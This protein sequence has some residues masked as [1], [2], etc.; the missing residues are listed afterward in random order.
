V[1]ARQL[2]VNGLV[3]RLATADLLA[4]DANRLL[5]IHLVCT[6]LLARVGSGP[7][8]RK[9]LQLGRVQSAPLYSQMDITHVGSIAHVLVVD[10]VVSHLRAADGLELLLEAL[11]GRVVLDFVRADDKRVGFGRF[12]GHREG[13]KRVR[14]G[15]SVW[16]K[17]EYIN[18]Q[19]MTSLLH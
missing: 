13:V 6:L 11:V 18:A 19:T 4:G 8:A 9:V 5:L 3:R 10:V 14:N 1:D 7:V 16:I 17:S 12:Y 2:S 15:D